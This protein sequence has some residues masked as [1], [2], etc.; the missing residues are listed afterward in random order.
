MRVSLCRFKQMLPE[1]FTALPG[2]SCGILIALLTGC[3]DVTSSA[4]GSTSQPDVEAVPVIVESIVQKPMPVRLESIGNVEA[5]TTVAM[6]AL[7][8]GQIV[9]VGFKEGE[10]VV[11]GQVLFE[12]DARPFAAQLKQ[13]EATLRRD[14]AQVENARA[15]VKKNQNLSEK[16]FSSMDAYAQLQ[17]NVDVFAATVDVD[18]AAVEAARLQLEY[19]TI[20]APITGRA[21]KIM[22]QQGNFV[23]ANDTNPLV[24]INQVDPI[25]VSVSVLAQY[26]PEI[27]EWMA[28]GPLRVMVTP[29]YPK[30]IP[31][32]GELNF[33][34]NT[35][36]LSTGTIKLKATF[37][38][39]NHEL[40]P[41]Q[42]VTTV[43]IVREEPDAIVV[44]SQAL[45]RGPRGPYV[46]VV[47]PDGTAE[48]RDITV[49]RTEGSETVVAK[50]LV[51][52]ERVHRRPSA[53]FA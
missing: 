29:S 42:F 22:L 13:A 2:L 51:A 18:R 20:R 31:T 10:Q 3:T 49:D 11:K 26:R 9:S 17:T 52:G 35:V 45:H 27:E 53:P 34:D 7:V 40:W 38:N 44:P 24:I 19:T 50:G 25:Y 8:D 23:K 28:R 32:V 6:K 30:H 39:P 46:F 43:L 12:L 5:Y 37:H 47:T 21:G 48:L 4:L 15:Q 1:R 41:G 33:M 36:D 14:L 16:R